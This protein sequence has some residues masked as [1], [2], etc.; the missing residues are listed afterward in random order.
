VEESHVEA[1]EK[2]EADDDQVAAALQA[3]EAVEE[4]LQQAASVTRIQ[5][6]FLG[7]MI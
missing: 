7:F 4:S 3:L 2:W 1:G 5:H 6:L